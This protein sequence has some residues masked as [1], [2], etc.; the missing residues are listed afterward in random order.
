L[1]YGSKNKNHSS[2]TALEEKNVLAMA[3]TNKEN[4]VSEVA[5]ISRW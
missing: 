2:G 5:I 1:F 4:I 3:A